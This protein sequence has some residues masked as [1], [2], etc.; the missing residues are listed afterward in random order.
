MDKRPL[1]LVTGASSGIGAAY[2][3]RFA[4]DG[5]DLIVVARRT[6]RLKE[7][8]DRLQKQYGVDVEVL[9]ADLTVS[10]DIARVTSRIEGSPGLER[11][12]NNAGFGGFRPFKDL[13]Y[14]QI[15]ALI[16]VHVRAVTHL[17]RAAIGVML[18]KGS[19]A[20][21]NVSSLMALGGGFPPERLPKRATYVGA[22]SFMV[23]FTQTLAQEVAETP[24]R[25]Q[26]CLPP[27]VATEF[28][29]GRQTPIPPMQADDVVDAS[30]VAL[31][32]NEVVCIPG[33]DDPSLIERLTTAQRELYFA[34]VRPAKSS[35]YNV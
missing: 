8:S 13:N 16:D 10:K 3:Q 21:I 5:F 7:L 32:R 18:S 29:G 1:A 6:E 35:R 15:D 30:L 23:T 25:V 22:K 33:L 28:Y 14:A 11:L 27:V 31:Q 19:G 17:T 24:V 4:K 26:I 2:A 20:V 12:V 34:G 9:T